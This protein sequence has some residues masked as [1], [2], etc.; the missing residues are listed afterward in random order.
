MAVGW[1]EAAVSV[2]KKTVG[3]AKAV[4]GEGNRVT[5]GSG[6]MGGALTD[7]VHARDT[8]RIA[9]K[10]R[11]NRILFMVSAMGSFTSSE[12]NRSLSCPPP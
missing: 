5:S 4:T 10:G 11:M 1:K 8:I 7:R 2:G 6:V 12:Y 9:V 3:E